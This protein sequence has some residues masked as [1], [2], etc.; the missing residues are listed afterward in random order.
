MTGQIEEVREGVDYG[1]RR[2]TLS[3]PGHVAIRDGLNPEERFL[4]GIRIC[5]DCRPTLL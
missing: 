3:S 1:V 4:K 5:R 2:R